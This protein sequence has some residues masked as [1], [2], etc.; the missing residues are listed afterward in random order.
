MGPKQTAAE[1]DVSITAISTSPTVHS[2]SPVL[3]SE[4]KRKKEL[5]KTTKTFLRQSALCVRRFSRSPAQPSPPPR[6]S[7]AGTVVMPSNRSILARLVPLL[8]SLAFLTTE[9]NAQNVAPQL[10]GTWSTGNGAVLTG[11]VRS[12]PQ[13]RSGRR[14]SRIPCSW[15]WEQE[16]AHQSCWDGRL[17]RPSVE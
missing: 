5:P 8:L 13:S 2:E 16:G 17:S 7:T 3:Q 4:R 12:F 15:T 11:P 9:T 14:I 6:L 1:K 10:V